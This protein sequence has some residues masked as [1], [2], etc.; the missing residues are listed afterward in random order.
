MVIFTYVK[1]IKS[2][3]MKKLIVAIRFGVPGPLPKEMPLIRKILDGEL[4]MGAGMPL[5]DMGVVSLFHTS[6]TPKEIEEG[7]KTL[8]EETSDVLPIIAFELGEDRVGFD[9]QMP[10]FQTMVSEMQE[11]VA[12]QPTV[13]HMTLDQLLDLVQARGGVANLMPEELARLQELSK[14]CD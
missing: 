4:G 5:A 9:L 12:K 14:N 3:N 11:R 10:A 2:R 1:S 13:N 8:A 7:F 6:W